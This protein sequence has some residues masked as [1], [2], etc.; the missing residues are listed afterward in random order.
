M[1]ANADMGF[2][3]VACGIML[4]FAFNLMFTVSGDPRTTLC[5]I[6]GA[7]AVPSLA[8]LVMAFWFCPESPRYHLMKG[9]NYSTEQALK[10]L[11]KVRNTEVCIEA[12]SLLRS[13]K[14]L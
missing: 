5:L 8:L 9:P 12:L 14:E 1:A 6:Q 13:K 3:R 10:I 2:H 11:R 4:G 7:P